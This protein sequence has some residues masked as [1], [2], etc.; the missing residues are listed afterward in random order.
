MHFHTLLN[1]ENEKNPWYHVEQRSIFFRPAA[2]DMTLGVYTET[3][4]GVI[5]KSKSTQAVNRVDR[6]SIQRRRSSEH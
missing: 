3:Q 5:R 1:E 2:R 4:S 6:R